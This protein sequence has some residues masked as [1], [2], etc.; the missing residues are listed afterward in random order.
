MFNNWEY[1]ELRDDI[2][3]Q[4]DYKLLT[5]TNWTKLK[6]A[7]GGGPEIPFFQYQIET[8]KKLPDGTVETV[9]ES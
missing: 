3:F 9:K 6:S 5:L 8:E 2:E 4:R 7:F 1:M